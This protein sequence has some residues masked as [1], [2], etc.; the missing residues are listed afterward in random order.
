[1]THAVR[2]RYGMRVRVWI[3]AITKASDIEDKT[4]PKTAVPGEVRFVGHLVKK[5]GIWSE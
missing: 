1:M 2:V 4:R 5:Q 3:R